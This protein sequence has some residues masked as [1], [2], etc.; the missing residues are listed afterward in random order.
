VLIVKKCY[1]VVC[2]FWITITLTTL[3]KHVRKGRRICLF[4][5][6]ADII[7]LKLH[8][9]EEGVALNEVWRLGWCKA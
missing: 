4:M 1:V 3:R 2:F 7:S 9:V 6:Y 5:P 8:M